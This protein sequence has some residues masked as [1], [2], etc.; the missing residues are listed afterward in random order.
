[1]PSEKS[2]VASTLQD[3]LDFLV[4]KKGRNLNSNDLDLVLKCRSSGVTLRIFTKLLQMLKTSTSCVG[5]RQML[6]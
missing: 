6:S 1:M 4:P 2:Q 5:G 3:Y